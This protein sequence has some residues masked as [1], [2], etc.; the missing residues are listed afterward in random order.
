[1]NLFFHRHLFVKYR[2][3]VSGK[4]EAKSLDNRVH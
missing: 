3:R 4:D 1:M 2:G